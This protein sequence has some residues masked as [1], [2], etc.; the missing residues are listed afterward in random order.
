MS[1][2]DMKHCAWLAGLLALALAAA[3]SVNVELGVSPGQD[4]ADA[5][6]DTA[7]VSPLDAAGD[8]HD[9]ADQ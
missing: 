5:G 8:S 7:R 3:C 4:A 6:A 1:G 9:G 2:S